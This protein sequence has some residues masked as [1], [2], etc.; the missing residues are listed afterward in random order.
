M[1]VEQV[2]QRS[3]EMISASR[4]FGPPVERDGVT[5]V[6]VAWV[7]GGGGGGQGGPETPGD[8]AGFGVLS[9]PIGAYV[10]KDGAVRFSPTYDVGVLALI[11][12]SLVRK[13]LKR[14]RRR[15]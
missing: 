1:E 6:P 11:G 13:M 14:A 8:G 4:V 9:I 3:G 2:L 5:L 12:A 10:I 7:L 15:R